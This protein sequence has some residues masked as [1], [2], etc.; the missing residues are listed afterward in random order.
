MHKSL[1]IGAFAIII[2]GCVALIPS[3]ARATVYLSLDAEEGTVGQTIPNPPFCQTECSGSGAKGTFESAD[4]AAQGAQ[5]YQ[6]RT[7]QSQGEAYTVVG[8]AGQNPPL[9]AD[10]LG[11]TLYLGW[12]FNFTRIDGND[13]WHEGQLQSGDKGVE[14]R[15]PGVRWGV[16]NGQWETVAANQDHRYTVWLGN[17]TYHLNPELEHVDIY[18]PNQSGYSATHT[19]QLD[20]ENWHSAVLGVHFAFDQTGWVGVWID[21]E[22]VYD[23]ANIRT[24]SSAEGTPRI[25]HL[26]LNGTIAQGALDAPPHLRKYDAFLLTDNWQ[27]VID[28]G[29]LAADR[30]A[31]AAPTNLSV[32]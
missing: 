27:D 17:P 13:I 29:Y 24:A 14:I 23:Y 2:L 22:K 19:I 7:V 25:A 4:G 18:F 6:W 16:A 31:P 1:H 8:N 10:L 30:L 3:T 9:V 15:G 12:Y 11:K 21:G 28:G 26:T 5:Y 32:Q 20:Y